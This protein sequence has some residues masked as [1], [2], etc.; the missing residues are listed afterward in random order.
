MNIARNPD[1]TTQPAY[2]NNAGAAG[3]QYTEYKLKDAAARKAA[4]EMVRKVTAPDS[5]VARALRVIT[6]NGGSKIFETITGQD[7]LTFGVKDFT[8]GGLLPLVELIEKRHPG[9]VKQAFGADTRVLENGWLAT[10]TSARNDHGL[11]ALAE[12]RIGLDRILCDARFYDEQLDRFVAEAV[13]PTL[14]K[15]EDR[16]YVREFSLAAMIGAANS[17]GSGGL[18]KWLSQAETKTGSKNEEVVIPEFMRIY[19]M[20]DAGDKV[21]A[22]QDLLAKVFGDKQGELPDWDS[23]GHSGRRLRWLAEYFSWKSG[24]AFVELGSFGS[25]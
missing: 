5:F 23:L 19:T 12:V 9:A 4:V 17:G 21:T 6:G 13:E 1:I 10:H 3:G 25:P 11:V 7:G 16:K 18:E 15:F 22:T 20:R 8:S 24:Q 2:Q 14:K